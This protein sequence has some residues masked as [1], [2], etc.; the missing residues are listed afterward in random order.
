MFDAGVDIVLGTDWLTMDPWANMRFGIALNRQH[1][2]DHATA[3]AL[4]MLRRSTIQPARALGLG[5]RIGSLEPNKQAD[6]LLLDLTGP[7][8]TPMFHDPVVTIVYN[9]CRG[10]VTD[11]MVDGRFTVRHRR[12]QTMD[13]AEIL[14]QGQKVA[15]EVYGRHPRRPALSVHHRSSKSK[16]KGPSPQWGDGPCFFFFSNQTRKK[17]RKGRIVHQIFQHPVVEGN[18]AQIRGCRSSA[19]RR[20]NPP[21][22]RP[23]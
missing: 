17:S 22:G 13:A 14:H 10:D 23:S 12:L 21:D 19:R 6:L 16:N 9:A 20:C 2:V 5:D 11:V 18:A 8:L 3:S 15:M 1:G 7:N 4:G